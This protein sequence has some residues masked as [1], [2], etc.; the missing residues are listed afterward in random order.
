[1]RGEDAQQG[2]L[3]SAIWTEQAENAGASREI[4]IPQHGRPPETMPNISQVNANTGAGCRCGATMSTHYRS[5][6]GAS[7]CVRAYAPLCQITIAAHTAIA[8]I[9]TGAWSV[10][11]DSATTRPR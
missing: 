7:S 8:A 4:D 3:A 5:C 6:H 11:V 10:S 9:Q 1:D 2:R